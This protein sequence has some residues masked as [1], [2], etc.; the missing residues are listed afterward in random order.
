MNRIITWCK[1]CYTVIKCTETEYGGGNDYS[2]ECRRCL[3]QQGWNEKPSLKDQRCLLVE[4]KDK[5]DHFKA[6]LCKQCWLT[7]GCGIE[8]EFEVNKQDNWLV[9]AECPNGVKCQCKI[10][11]RN[12]DGSFPKD[13]DIVNLL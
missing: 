2:G 5:C 12:K 13:V 4:C 6:E 8:K 1:Y 3:I 10:Y 7:S 9:C 11:K